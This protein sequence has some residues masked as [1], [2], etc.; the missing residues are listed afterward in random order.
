MF[1]APLLLGPSMSGPA[2]SVA[3][4]GHLAELCIP[5]PSSIYHHA[6]SDKSSYIFCQTLKSQLMDIERSPFL[7]LELGIVC[8]ISTHLELSI[9]TF[10][11]YLN[12]YFF[13]TILNKLVNQSE[14]L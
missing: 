6:L 8:L 5:L 14:H 1:S 11:L 7:D 10:K 2:F 12:T 3:P 9:D 4:P 13:R